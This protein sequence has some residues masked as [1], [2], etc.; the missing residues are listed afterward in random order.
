MKNKKPHLFILFLLSGAMYSQ[1]NVKPSIIKKDI[2]A[3]QGADIIDY[4]NPN[5]LFRG[6]TPNI[7]VPVYYNKK[8]YTS[9][10]ILKKINPD[11][12]S[13]EIINFPD[14]ISKDF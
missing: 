5:N 6:L 10:D 1:T 2:K 13:V 12:I 7:K 3:N 8:F 11:S 14:S 9:A 4:H